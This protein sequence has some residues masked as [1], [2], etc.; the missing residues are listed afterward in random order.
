MSIAVEREP[1]RFPLSASPVA[2]IARIKNES[3]TQQ[4]FTILVDGQTV[5][6]KSVPGASTTR[7]DC[8]WNGRWSL[9]ES[10]RVEIAGSQASWSLVFLEV[11]SH[12][13]ATRG[14]DLVILPAS[15]ERRAGPSWL[16]VVVFFVLTAVVMTLPLPS[17]RR[18]LLVS[19]RA[20]WIGVAVLLG[21]C[22]VSRF[23]TPFLVVVSVNLFWKCVAVAAVPRLWQA[24]VWSRANRAHA[25]R[26]AIVGGAAATLTAATYGPLVVRL[27]HEEFDGNYSGFLRMT[28]ARFDGHPTLSS[29]SALRE[30]LILTDGDGYD[31]QY[32]YYEVFDPFLREFRDSP[33]SYQQFIDEPPYRYGRIGFSLL[34]RLIAR[35]QWRL[36]PATMT[37]LVCGGVVACFAGFLVLAS[38]AGVSPFRAAVVIMIPAFWYSVQVALPEPIAGALLLGGYVCLVRGRRWW[39]AALFAASLL[40]RETGAIFVACLVASELISGHRRLSVMTGALAAAPILAWRAFI[41]KI[42]SPA[43]GVGAYWQSAGV[44]GWPLAGLGQMWTQIAH[45]V[46]FG[47]RADFAFAAIWFSALILGA[48]TIAAWLCVRRPEP[49]AFAALAY[50]VI[51]VSMTFDKVWEHIQNGQRGTYEVFLMLAIVFVGQTAQL[52]RNLRI[53]L[54]AFWIACGGYVFYGAFDAPYI[55]DAVNIALF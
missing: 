18:G 14:H 49:V 10:H 37:W 9:G 35:D 13:G 29:N 23:V 46:Y 55:R 16:V 25:W 7:L 48:L 54:W 8:A 38:G 4:R 52:P 33:I 45:G 42:L 6:R 50:A 3:S 31:G 15:F 36:Y 1:A 20:A 53:A 39:A 21:L 2:V 26:L 40:I 19:Y 12:H 47:G 30:S 41:G 51:A 27:L 22:V 44:F 43:F 11:A 24:A 5:C 28:A 32:L 34:T 17:M